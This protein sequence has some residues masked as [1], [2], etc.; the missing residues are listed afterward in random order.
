MAATP[1]STVGTPRALFETGLAVA[2]IVS[3]RPE[4][5]YEVTADGERFLVNQAGDASA[6]TTEMGASSIHVLL[7]WANGL[8][9]S[10]R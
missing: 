6:Q 1:P 9:L 7:N 10:S 5:L 2:S 3:A 8:A 4:S